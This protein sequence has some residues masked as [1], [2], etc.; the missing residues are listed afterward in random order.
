MNAPD[1]LQQASCWPQWLDDCRIDDDALAQA[2]DSTPLPLRAAV[3]QC[4]ALCHAVYGEG[5]SADSHTVTDAALGFWHS[6][7]RQ[8][9]PWALLIISPAYAAAARMAAALMPAILARVPRIGAVCVGGIPSLAARLTL[10]LTGVEDSFIVND[11]ELDALLQSMNKS[12]AGRVL[13]LHAGELAHSASMVRK[14]GIA[15]FE[16]CRPPLLLAAQDCAL[17]PTVLAFAHGANC[18][19]VTNNA[20]SPHTEPQPP[21][22]TA[23]YYAAAPSQP[24]LSHSLVLAQGMEGCWLH[25]GL[26]RAFFDNECFVV[27]MLEHNS[28]LFGGG[29]HEGAE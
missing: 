14:A 23:Y 15:C 18:P 21:A 4:M 11:D 17:D 10:E 7:S 28:S 3:K 6:H 5:A 13:L 22:R 1:T 12:G 24:P 8:P 9:A 16:E 29:K 27:G 25:A 2:Y 26:S 19:L 20:A